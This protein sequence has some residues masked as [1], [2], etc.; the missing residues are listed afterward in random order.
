[1]KIRESMKIMGLSDISF[2]MAWIIWYGTIF[3]II[4]FVFAVCSSTAIF[5]HSNFIV[6]FL[7]Y[8]LF[9]MNI[10]F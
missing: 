9:V 2:Y 6:I 7:W 8:W 3:T 5:K 4:A 1:M 10:M